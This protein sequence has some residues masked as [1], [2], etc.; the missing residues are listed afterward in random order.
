M[1]AQIS[2]KTS[3]L[4]KENIELLAQ[5][6]W[7][8]KQ[9][10]INYFK[11]HSSHSIML[12]TDSFWEWIDIPGDDL[13]YLI[14]HKFPFWVPTDPIFKARSSLYKDSFQDYSIPKAIIKTK[15][16]FWRL[17]RTK[18]DKWIFILLDDRIINTSW[19]EKLKSSF[20]KDVNFKISNSNTFLE[21]LKNKKS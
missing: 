15:Q 5:N 21:L 18:N 2:D 1:I 19:W 17:I 11:K 14:I 13:K 7:W 3:E 8:W 6:I 9:K 12:W 20:P 10:I 16:W 4:K